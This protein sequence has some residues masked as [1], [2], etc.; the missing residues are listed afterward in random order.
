[1]RRL[2]NKFRLLHSPYEP[3][4]VGK[5]DRTACL[6]RDALVVVTSWSSG[7]IPWPH[8][9]ALGHRGGSGLLVEEELARAVRTE[10]A[11]ALRCWRGVSGSTATL[12]RQALGVEGP[13]GTEG[14]RLLLQA[15]QQKAAAAMR[16]R[17]F[18]ER[19]RRA[20]RRRAGR[21]NQGQY[22][23]AARRKRAW[24]EE[25]LALLGT[26]PDEELARRLGKSENAV[27]L[28]RERRGIPNPSGPRWT[29]GELALL[30]TA[31][32]GEVARQI[33][34]T[35]MAVACKRCEQGIPRPVGWHWTD[36]Q[37]ALLGTAPDAEVAARI[38]KT[39]GAVCARRCRRGIPP[40]RDRRRRV[41]RWPAGEGVRRV[42]VAQ[43]RG[44]CP[45][46]LD[47]LGGGLG[48]Y[49]PLPQEPRCTTREESSRTVAG[50]RLEFFRSRLLGEGL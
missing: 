16:G 50:G 20:C 49:D 13:A 46:P 40:F 45:G 7:R 6:Y 8:C 5:G 10:S 4:P 36:E 28:Q 33:G 23:E 48:P 44:A 12:W 21:L 47:R 9:R 37:L 43:G 1:M 11:A 30:G 15:A 26:M 27:R 3:P 34:R 22:L 39:P 19:E 35:P 29:E 38:G 31:P 25:H 32:D 2:P 42:R 14:S 17:E 24:P 41:D 18:T